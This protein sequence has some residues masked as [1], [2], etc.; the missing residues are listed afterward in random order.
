MYACGLS[1]CIYIRECDSCCCTHCCSLGVGC[2]LNNWFSLST[3]LH[4]LMFDLRKLV[5]PYASTTT[6]VCNA[7]RLLKSSDS[8]STFPRSDAEATQLR[9]EIPKLMN[10]RCGVASGAQKKI[11]YCPCLC[12][13]TLLRTSKGDTKLTVN[14]VRPIAF[15]SSR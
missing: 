5:S 7:P 1:F 3:Q 9:F 4:V 13:G 10:E 2:Y 15:V 12:P 6:Y 14:G 8:L 11:L